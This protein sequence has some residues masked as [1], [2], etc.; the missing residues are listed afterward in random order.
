MH[1]TKMDK[2]TFTKTPQDLTDCWSDEDRMEFLFSAF[3][4]DVSNKPEHWTAK[5]NFW[6]KLICDL[7]YCSTSITITKEDILDVV[8]R[9]GKFPLGFETIWQEMV[10]KGQIISSPEYIRNLN[11]NSSWVGWSINILL[12]KPSIWIA[13][14][15]LSP[16]KNEQ[17]GLGFVCHD[18][19][20]MKCQEVYNILQNYEAKYN[21]SDNEYVISYQSIH[22]IT[23]GTVKTENC[24]DITLLTLEKQR[25]VA[26][27]TLQKEGKSDGIQLQPVKYIKFSNLS[28]SDSLPV[29]EID[30]GII[31]LHHTKSVL[32]E[33]IE[34]LYSKQNHLANT[35]RKCVQD[36]QRVLAKHALRQKQLLTKSIHDK[37]KHLDNIDQ[38]LESIEQSKVDRLTLNAFKSGLAAHKLFVKKAGLNEDSAAE[39]MF[40]IADMIEYEKEMSS[41]MAREVGDV[42]SQEELETELNNLLEESDKKVDEVDEVENMISSLE[43]LDKLPDVKS[44]PIVSKDNATT[45][46]KVQTS[47]T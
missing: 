1:V 2:T 36:K 10:K 13:D 17:T 11:M 12:R 40:E 7:F 25:K 46:F 39:T 19:L 34:N 6:T 38:M 47:L 42:A 28:N 26:V 27:F 35:A 24:L 4:P 16:I 33:Q 30:H 37:E 43:I 3:P 31:H 8:K 21:L 14:K 44:L 41:T 18:S 9:N 22:K 5:M 32:V 23:K 20:Q 15:V 45:A 29:T